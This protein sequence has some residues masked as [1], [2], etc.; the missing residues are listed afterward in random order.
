LQ[1]IVLAAGEGRRLR[2]LTTHA[3]KP[4]V[5]VLNRPL[6]EHHLAALRALGITDVLVNTHHAPERL[7]AHF[8]D[9]SAFGV[10]ITWRHEATLTGP[11]GAMRAFEDLLRPGPLLVLSGDGLHDIDL[12]ALIARHERRA[13]CL[14]VVLAEVDRAGRYGVATV[15]PDG[16]VRSFEEKPAWAR[17]RRGLVSCGVY[18]LDAG[19]LPRVPAGAVYDFGEHLIPELVAAGEPVLGLVHAGYWQ[20]IGTVETFWRSNLDAL[21]GRVRLPRAT[22][23]IAGALV[24]EE[25]TVSPAATI[26]RDVLVGPRACVG[27]GAAVHGPSVI[28]PDCVI[29]AGAIVDRSVL[30]PRGVVPSGAGVVN[31]VVFAHDGGRV[32][33]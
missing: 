28:G 20:D 14:T 29:E 23:A 5:P 33:L 1:A 9:G 2:P 22:A 25:A 8:G 19:L 15:D 18:C 4:L 12:A 6:L 27:P 10:H 13:P 24:S 16:L 7:H 11:A 17:D 30:L 26:D 3:P 31:G 21:T 32:V